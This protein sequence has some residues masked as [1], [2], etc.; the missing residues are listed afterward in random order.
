[1]AANTTET[2]PKNE[3]PIATSP[4]K[5][6][7]KWQAPSK[8]RRINTIDT[9]TGGEPTRIIVSGLPPIHGF[10][11]LEKR[12]YFQQHYDHLRCGL[13]LE[14]R[15]HA[16]MYGA[17]LTSPSNPKEADLDVFFINTHGYSSMCGHATLGITKVVF[18]TG[19][20]E[21]NG[22]ESREIRLSSPAG[23][24]NTRA[25]FDDKTGEV[26]R[27]FFLNV[28]SFVYQ[29]D[30]TV[31]VPGLGEVT[32]DICFGGVFFAIVSLDTLHIPQRLEMVSENSTSFVSLGRKIRKAILDCPKIVVEHPINSDLNELHG[33][34]F[35]GPPYDPRN[36]SRNVN[37][38]ED[39]EIDRSPTGTGVS[40]RAALHLARGELELGQEFTVE[41]IVG[42][43]MTGRVIREVQLGGFRA[44]I[45]EVSGAA[46][47]VSQTE[48][49]FDPSDPFQDG[50]VLH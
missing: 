2:A 4:F 6:L 17:I 10:N 28:P 46:H 11:V 37:V 36:H 31:A 47:I 29:L 35:T 40:A 48:L 16:D 22:Q 43:T 26:L 33:V 42:S 8:Y 41:S 19:L 27:A 50:F 32:F 49:L 12:R 23:I 30:Q 21:K 24:V 39:G 34:I 13:L 20:V 18:E 3:V 5:P 38:F 1:M 44:V 7:W 45:P 9:H 14:P 15:G 25:T